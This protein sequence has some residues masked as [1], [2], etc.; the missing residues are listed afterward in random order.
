MG[1]FYKM[2]KVL[3]CFFIGIFEKEC[4]NHPKKLYN[5]MDL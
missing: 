3:Q 1:T 5:R 2:L 4:P